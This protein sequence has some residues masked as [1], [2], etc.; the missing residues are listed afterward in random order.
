MDCNDYLMIYFVE[1]FQSCNFSI[2]SFIKGKTKF[3]KRYKKSL[4]IK[5]KIAEN[6]AEKWKKRYQNFDLPSSKQKEKNILNVV[7]HQTLSFNLNYKL[8]SFKPKGT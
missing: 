4:L 5:N 1:N 8:I 6:E 2:E 3:G 7:S